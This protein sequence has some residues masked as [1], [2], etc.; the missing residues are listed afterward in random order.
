LQNVFIFSWDLQ[1]ERNWKQEK[2]E[3]MLMQNFGGTNK[4]YYGISIKISFCL[5]PLEGLL[6]L[7]YISR[8]KKYRSGIFPYLLS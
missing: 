6:K 4:E 1:R 8:F 5:Q 2:L 3:T 7:H